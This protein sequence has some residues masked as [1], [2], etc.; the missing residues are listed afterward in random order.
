[1]AKQQIILSSIALLTLASFFWFGSTVQNKPPSTVAVHDSHPGKFKI[2]DFISKAKLQLSNARVLYLGTLENSIS[3]GDVHEQTHKKYQELAGFWKDSAKV[4]EPYAYYLS[5]SA[6]LDNSEKSLTF[7]ARMILDNLR[8][9]GDA[10]LRTWK[11]EMAITLFEQAL[12]LNPANDSLKVGLGSCYIYGMGMV[13]DAEETMKGIQKLLEVV[14]K[15]SL[16]MQAQ[17]V[18]GIGG[19]IS[20]QYDKSIDR[21]LKVVA[22]EPS[23]IEAISWLAD[24]YASSGDKENAIR[25]Y[26]R[27]KKLMNN[28]A[29]SADVDKRIRML[30]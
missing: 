9:E 16:N 24:A 12:I 1:M 23:N 4:F 17:L 15:D 20:M 5:E 13:G 22:A 18:L 6:K 10:S 2:E 3:R 7:A 25:W 19:V 26:D 11:S 21:L 30:N 8:S 14:R 28:S 27:S 29:F